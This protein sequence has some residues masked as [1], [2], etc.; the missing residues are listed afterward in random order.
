MTPSN[1]LPPDSDEHPEQRPP[2]EAP[3][4][5]PLPLK[6]GI[7]V[8]GVLLLGAVAT[9]VWGRAVV[10]YY[11]IPR[12]EHALEETLERPVHVGELEHFTL[13]GFRIGPS[14]FPPTAA[15]QTEARAR[16][17]DVSISWPD[18]IFQQTIRPSLTLLDPE[19][20]VMQAADGRWIDLTLPQPDE[21]DDG[22]ISFKLGELRVDNARVSLTSLVPR[23]EALVV[24]E[25]ILLES[26]EGRIYLT[27][28]EDPEVDEVFFEVAGELGEGRFQAQGNGLLEQQALNVR[29]QTHNLPTV[30]VNWVLPPQLGLRGGTLDSHV[31]ARVRLQDDEQPI[32]A[33]GT[34]QFQGGEVLLSQ[35]PEPI[36]DL[37]TTL[38][39]QGD[40][41]QLE[42]TGLTLGEIPLTVA[43]MVD[44][45]QG[46]DLTTAIAAMS[47]DQVTQLLDLELPVAAAGVFQFDGAVTGPLDRPTL[48]GSLANLGPV[49][50]DQVTVDTLVANIAA[51][52]EQFTLETLRVV[53]AAGG[54]LTGQGQVDLRDLANPSFTLAL[55][56]DLPG[57]ALAALYGVALPNQGVIGPVQVVGDLGG[58]LADP[59]ALVQFQLPGA[60]YP[61]GGQATYR[62]G[63]LVVDQT[64]FQVEEGTLD[65]TALVE[66][67]SGAWSAEMITTAVPLERL[68]PQAR[69]LLTA[70]VMASG[71]LQR[72][73]LAAIQAQGTAVVADAE[74]AL[75]PGSPA[76]L[77]R[78][79]W[80]TDFRWVGNGLQV[81]RFDAPGVRA[82]GFIATQVGMT[83]LVDTV[84]LA[85]QL[86]AYNLERLIPFLP[87]PAR[88]QVILTGLTSFEGQLTG[89]LANLRLR[90]HT[91]LD[92]LGVN[93]LAFE[94]RLAGPIDMALAEGGTLDL[95]GNRDRL[96]V[97]LDRDL[98]PSQFALRQG[99]MTAEGRMVNRQLIATLDQFPLEALAL[100]PAAGLGSLGGRLGATLQAD[101]TDLA[102][103]TAQGLVTVANPALGEVVAD[104]FTG[105][106]HYGAGWLALA[107]GDLRLADSQY[108]LSGQ[109]NVAAPVVAYSGQVDIVAG[110]FEDLL[111]TLGWTD[112][113]DVGF[114]PPA[115]ATGQA[116]DMA[117]LPA[118]LP[119]RSFLE[120]LRAFGTFMATHTPQANGSQLAMPPLDALEG[121]FAGSITIQGEGFTAETVQVAAEIQGQDWRWGALLPCG[122]TPLGQPPI[123]LTSLALGEAGAAAIPCNQFQLSARYQDGALVISPLDFR[124]P[125]TQIS[126][127]GSGTLD[128]LDGQL[129]ATGIPVELVEVFLDLPVAVQGELATT[130]QLG[131]SLSHPQVVGQLTVVEPTLNQQP[132]QGVAVDYTYDN[133]LLRFDG[134]AV[135]SDPGHITLAGT[136]P[137]ALPFMAVQPPTDQLDVRVNL[138]NESLQLLN[139]LTAEQ[140][141]WEGGQG[142]ISLQVGGTLAE[143]VVTGQAQFRQGQVASSAL[144]QPITDLNGSV[145]FNLEQVQVNQLQAAFGGGTIVAQGRLP[146]HE[147][148]LVLGAR[149]KQAPGTTGIAIALNQ[150]QVDYNDLL[151]AQVEGHVHIGGAVL[152][153]AVSGVVQVSQGVVQANNLL[154]QMGALGNGVDPGANLTGETPVPPS[155][156]TPLVVPLTDTVARYRDQ[157]GGFEPL[158]TA[159]QSLPNQLM[160]RVSLQQF[161]LVLADQL[162]ISGQ[163]FYNLAAA[164]QIQVNGTLADPRPDGVITLNTGWINLFSTQFRLIPGETNTATFSPTHGLDPF[165]DVRLRARVQ[166]AEI[167]ESATVSPFLSADVSDTP[168]LT[169]GSVEFVNVFATAYGY[170][171]ELQGANTPGQVTELITLS[172]RPAR[173][174]AD[175]VTL[176]GR[177]VLTN[178]YGA[179]L[180]QVAGFLGS[181]ALAGFGDR[182]AD[183]V[184][185]RSF[186]V[187]PTTDT[188]RDSTAGIGIGMEAAFDIGDRISV[189]AL[190]ILNSG[191][192]PEVGVSYRFSN[193]L[194]ARGSTN[195]SGNETVT[196]EYEIRF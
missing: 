99:E 194:R 170:A 88:P 181:G 127:A 112:F 95:Q 130:A 104:R 83:P 26:V 50:A 110:H 57:D 160:Q 36:Q 89:P 156:A 193:Q 82:S 191:N 13:T 2:A 62:H 10:N 109:A 172:S 15:V 32:S 188:A 141:R 19:V 173:P 8:G 133:A 94:P 3:P 122:P 34:A 11:V 137:Y 165:L 135:V 5:W 24:A 124:S 118:S 69:G 71:N 91:Q 63:A 102:N 33:R 149:P 9:A 136:V 98:L 178:I 90:G 140:L 154:G 58:T 56:A 115:P 20:V 43:G 77:E 100:A 196:V 134:A 53:P 143:P 123:P 161:N 187:F 121:Q 64:Q 21:E 29:V 128:N 189:D 12:L 180:G 182:I 150:L 152:A 70:A 158:P 93:A 52:L 49:Q 179:S 116:A 162:L 47:F 61:G 86:Q 35:L 185:L 55:E 132:L 48:V 16:A 92:G 76:V 14:H 31:T 164:G 129:T 23:P 183:V 7:G 177:S 126:L 153:P 22:P 42:E 176:L 175:L 75:A 147:P 125:T 6:A 51:S 192:P 157:M 171:S 80:T 142:E 190:E 138:Q 65:A 4:V 18:L 166:D 159:P 195:F 174:Q 78:G 67:D 163:P 81:E 167:R 120:Q 119:N 17:I 45:R 111:D 151:A 139:L 131:G 108:R 68:T 103:P 97:T 148:A 145:Q 84:D 106:Y 46:Y 41:V 168:G 87:E 101:L 28:L 105:Q 39:F 85:V 79:D 25:T 1:P 40:R 146:L 117:T 113:S 73:G 144:G 38:R 74:V 107:D 114:A 54:L 37:N 96:G 186:S 44:F 184:G 66:F 60:T 27:P 30:G 155:P 59:Q 72:L 169:T